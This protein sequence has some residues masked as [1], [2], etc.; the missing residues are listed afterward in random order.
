MAISRRIVKT[1]RPIK[2]GNVHALALITVIAS[3]KSMF[4]NRLNAKHV[5]RKQSLNQ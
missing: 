5:L 3:M 2:L 4:K 1:L